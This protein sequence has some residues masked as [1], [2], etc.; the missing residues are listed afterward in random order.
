MQG[1]LKGTKDKRP[2]SNHHRY[3]NDNDNGFLAHTIE[4]SRTCV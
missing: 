1:L 3:H 4:L 2:W